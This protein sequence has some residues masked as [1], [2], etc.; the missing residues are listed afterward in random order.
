M[1]LAVLVVGAGPAGLAAA[2]ALSKLGVSVRVIDKREAPEVGQRGAGV[3]P[4][5]L[6]YHHILGSLPDFLQRAVNLL[7]MIVYGPD[8]RTP[9]HVKEIM[10]AKEPTPGTPWPNCMILWQSSHEE[11]LRDHLLQQGVA[12]EWGTELTSFEQNQDTVVSQVSNVKS[13]IETVPSQYLVAADGSRSAVRKRLELSF[14]GE[15]TIEKAIAGHIEVKNLP[16]DKWHAWGTPQTQMIF[17]APNSDPKGLETSFGMVGIS[18]AVDKPFTGSRDQFVAAFQEVSGRTD[19]E[20]GKL[21]SSSLFSP[22]IRMVGQFSQG[23]CFLAGDAAHVHSPSGGQGLNSGIQ[24]SINLS[25]KLAAVIKGEAPC[26]LLD[27]YSDERLP[28]IAAMLNK[29]T[30]LH[31]ATF[32]D[33][34]RDEKSAAWRRG[35]ELLMLGINYRSSA[36]ALDTVHAA[37]TRL[38]TDPYHGGTTLCAGDRAPQ[39]P[40]LVD[41]TGKVTSLFE[42]FGYGHHTLLIFAQSIKEAT[43]VVSWAS[44]SKSIKPVV[45]L[46]QG[47]N[48][49]M[50]HVGVLVVED[51]EGH[52]YRTYFSDVKEE[53]TVLVPVRPDLHIGAMVRELDDL[54]LYFGKLL[55][56]L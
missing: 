36:L 41:V 31:K 14:L 20:F 1:V 27:T 51:R 48:G 49:L 28:V 42:I 9:A 11:I 13:G 45:V 23:R 2:L 29:T 37:K 8:G 7:P 43:A 40:G 52:A 35:D 56:G 30:L 26:S 38:S 46:P 39:A 17:L 3:Q 16:R 33:D 54:K 47:S 4:R 22:N 15:S 24:D 18:A 53:K 6:E 32:K 34:V 50:E 10:P 44:I 5:T 55:A 19:I 12:V 25:W 21:Y